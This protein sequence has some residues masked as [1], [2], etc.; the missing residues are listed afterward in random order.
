MQGIEPKIHTSLI[1]RMKYYSDLVKNSKH[2]SCINPE[3]AHQMMIE[4]NK[5]YEDYLNQKRNLEK[6]IKRYREFYQGQQKLLTPRIR[7]LK[8]T[9]K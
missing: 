4:L 3:D 9:R 1:E 6:S 5:L 8:R 2:D 7:Q